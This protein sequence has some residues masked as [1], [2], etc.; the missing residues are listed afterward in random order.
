[1]A[2]ATTELSHAAPIKAR[3][4]AFFASL[5]QGFNAY[6]ERKSR[7]TEIAHLQAKTDEELAAMGLK[8]D[9][10]AHYVFRDLYYI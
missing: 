4:D 9:D 2:N 3:L 5:G 6:L 10:I 7:S 1:M 8:R